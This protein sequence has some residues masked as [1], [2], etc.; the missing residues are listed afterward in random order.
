MASLRI[1]KQIGLSTFIIGLGLATSVLRVVFL[2]RSLSINEYGVLSVLQTTMMVLSYLFSL[3]AFQ[4]VY[5]ETA[6]SGLHISALK[7]IVVGVGITSLFWTLVGTLLSPLLLKSGVLGFGL[8]EWGLTLTASALSAIL[9]VLIYF[10]YGQRQVVFYNLL[11]FLRGYAWLYIL[12][13]TILLFDARLTVTWVVASWVMLIVI[14]LV[15]AVRR[16]GFSRL[17]RAPID[18]SWFRYSIKYGVPLLP[19]FLSIWGMLAISK[20]VLTYVCDSIQVALFSLAYTIF[21]MVYLVSVSVSQTLSPYIFADWKE[22]NQSS[23]YFEVALKYSTLLAILLALEALLVSEQVIQLL[24]GEVYVGASAFMPLMAPLPLLRV[25][26]V[27]LE[28]RLMATNRTRQMGAIYVICLL[29][30]L[31]V[32]LWLGQVWGVNGVVAALL[33]AHIM[34]LA[35]M[36]W[37]VRGEIKID[38]KFLS[39]YRIFGSSMSLVFLVYLWRAVSPLQQFQFVLIIAMP[40]IYFF[41]L[42]A[43]KA[44]SQLE[45]VYIMSMFGQIVGQIKRFISYRVWGRN[46]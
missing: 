21:D 24:A 17:N 4:Y 29:C 6:A 26:S 38:G 35:M 23:I 33:F 12:I 30:T 25:L 43:W 15:Q 16:I 28:Q 20:Y 36:A 2:T 8:L 9:F 40:G 1:F 22:K 5:K 13:P 19:F 3:G 46:V 14:A 10:L 18:M 11:L 39:F 44:I 41:L 31:V 42:Y 37:K 7:S 27:S 45:I 32:G 34:L